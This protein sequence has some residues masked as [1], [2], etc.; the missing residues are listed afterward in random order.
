MT[1]RAG[2]WVEVRSKE[3]ILAALDKNG[4]LDGMPFMPQ[5]FKYCGQRF[6]V[7]KHAHKT[8]DTINEPAGLWVNG[9]AIHL[10]LRCDG[11]AYAGCQAACMIFWKTAWLKPVSG[12]QSRETAKTGTASRPVA[13]AGKG[14]TEQDVWD[15]THRVDADGQTRY[16][17]QIVSLPDCTSKLPWWNVKQY[18]LDYSYGNVSA[19]GLVQQAAYVIYWH[20]TQAY[21]YRWGVGAPGRWLYDQFQKLRGGTPFPFRRGLIPVGEPTPVSVLNLQPGE[22]VR[23]KSHREIMATNNAKNRNNG[24]GFDVEMV[25]YC[26]KV[27]RVRARVHKF[28]DEKTGLPKYMKTPAVILED[29]WCRSCYSPHR[30]GCPRS[31]YSWWREVWLE[32]VNEKALAEALPAGCAGK[33]ADRVVDGVKTPVEVA[34]P[35]KARASAASTPAES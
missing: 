27:F 11:E 30:M 23:V 31:I 9:D 34:A 12:P 21:R 2:D 5:M 24:M 1:I 35:S 10:N 19:A 25:P 14:C 8:C 7:H 33:V 28:L 32:R 6:Q 16:R 13:A 17:C 29:V 26:G 20:A 3:E 22:L 15:A 18:L 4:R